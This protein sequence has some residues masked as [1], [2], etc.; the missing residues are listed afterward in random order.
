MHVTYAHSIRPGRDHVAITLTKSVKPSVPDYELLRPIGGGAYGEVWLARNLATGA[1]R[2]AKLV[3]RHSFE[4]ERPFRR[5]FEGLQRFEKISRQHPSQL[6]LFHIGRNDSEGYFYYVM[7]LADAVENPRSE[8]DPSHELDSGTNG[9]APGPTSSRLSLDLQSSDSY[10]KPHTLR[11]ELEHGR[12]PAERVLELG[13]ALTEALSNLHSHG[14]VHRDV[15]PSNVIFVNGRPKLADIGLVTESGDGRS[16]VGTEG[17]MAPEGPGAAQADLFAL[18]KVLYEAATGMDRRRF[19]RLPPELRSWPGAKLVLELNEVIVKA[20]APRL[21]ERYAAADEIHTDLTLLKVG[22]SVKRL[23]SVERRLSLMTRAAVLVSLCAVAGSGI[24][25]QIYH[26]QQ[27]ALRSLVRLRVSEGT[28]Q[29]NSGDLFG[30]LLSFTEALRLE[31]GDPKLEEP[32]RIRIASVLRQCPKLVGIFAHSNAPIN[33]AVFSP[34][35]RR[36]ITAGDDHIVQ[37]WDLATGQRL[38]S[39]MHTGPVYSVGITRDGARI[40]TTSSDNLVHLWDGQTGIPLPHLPIRHRSWNNGPSPEISPDSLKM[41]TL[42]DIR[43]VSLWNIGTGEPIGEPLRHD[44]EVTAFLFS[45]DSR[46]VLTISKD[47][48][49]RLWDASNGKP[50]YSFTHAATVNCGAFSLDSL[51]IATG[52]DDDCVKFWE[53]NSGTEI[54]PLLLHHHYVDFLAYSPDGTRLATA[55]RDRTVELWD[56]TTNRALLR[57]LLHDRKILRV[58]FSPDSRWLVSSSEGNRVRMWD[59]DTGQ[60]RAPALVHDTP[61]W[62]VIFSPDGHLMLTLRHDLSLEREEVA[63]VWNL[64]NKEP[65]ALRLRPSANFR[66]TA[67]SPDGRIKAVLS[68][69]I[70]RTVA[71]GSGRALTQPL[72]QSVPFRQ[73]FFSRDNTVLLAESAGGRGQ[74]WD[75]SQGEP[76][77]PMLPIEYDRNAQVP[78]RADLPR[79][80]RPIEYLVLLAELLSGNQVDQ[81]EGFRPLDRISLMQTWDTLKSKYQT[82]FAES[83]SET[84][85]WHEQEARAGEQAWNWWSARFHLQCLMTARPNDSALAARLAYCETALEN[86]R[87]KTSNYLAGRCSVI[88]PRNPLAKKDMIDLSAFFNLSRRGGDNSLAS[89]PSGLPTFGG[90]EFDVRGVVQLSD[91]DS[92]AASKPFPQQVKGIPVHQ[93]CRRLHFLHATASDTEDDTTVSRYVVHYADQRTQ[94]IDNLYGRHLRSWWTN[95]GESLT[96]EPQRGALVWMGTNPQAESDN[97]KSLRMFKRTWENPWPETEIASVDFESA[98]KGVGPFL[99]AITAE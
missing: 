28:R 79:D 19:P 87:R 77:T 62:P 43:T 65:P 96:A 45:P 41:L 83:P 98:G 54:L 58:G 60:L 42:P 39:L 69:E 94:R 59:A 30:S 95:I 72:K 49:A 1:R 9:M 73:V 66:K 11:Y 84:L 88:P 40:A 17:Y 67:S 57:P 89:L 55:C 14:L 50:I 24:F 71:I 15:K 99:L 26:Q 22:R 10:Y 61:R 52:G 20:C 92:Q 46:R 90:T 34:D 29:L 4:D 32:H 47:R 70:V 56:V 5:E 68:G 63:V 85:A 91:P 86:A 2:A 38:F 48:S 27:A 53:L 7:E 12:L 75:L 36:V 81:T 23:R 21:E 18:G 97:A 3:W 80:D 8:G 51:T 74:L 31:A 37:T 76:L 33:H 44:H 78:G 13:L 16:I 64:A 93:T 25:Y 82:S 6:A 35:S